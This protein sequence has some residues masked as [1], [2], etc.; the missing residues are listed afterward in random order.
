MSWQLQFRFILSRTQISQIQSMLQNHISLT[1]ILI[2]LISIFHA[3]ASKKII[4]HYKKQST[5]QKKCYMQ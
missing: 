3:T 2:I 5:S 4:S 1:Y